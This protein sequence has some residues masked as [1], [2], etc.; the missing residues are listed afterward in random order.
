MTVIHE[1]AHALSRNYTSGKM[2]K[3]AS[4]TIFEE[5]LAVAFSEACINEWIKDTEM[6][7][8]F[9]TG[10][11]ENYMIYENERSIINTFLL[12]LSKVNMDAKAMLEYLLGNKESFVSL[13]TDQI[14]EPFSEIFSLIET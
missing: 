1:Y 5:A 4:N 14:G 13:C 12:E 11:K 2:G 3:L 6:F 8:E 9:K 10:V 7:E